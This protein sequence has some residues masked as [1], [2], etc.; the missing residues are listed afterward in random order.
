[1]S[2]TTL[3][4]L[5]ALAFGAGNVGLALVALRHS[6][7][8]AITQPDARL[9]H[10]VNCLTYV[11]V[12]IAGVQ[13][14]GWQIQ[15]LQN[16]AVLRWYSA[17]ALIVWQALLLVWFVKRISWHNNVVHPNEGINP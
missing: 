14:I 6:R 12:L 4:R 15:A 10:R 9:A 11:A 3:V 1:M 17:P 5:V 7:E 16:H 13:A 2:F 8:L